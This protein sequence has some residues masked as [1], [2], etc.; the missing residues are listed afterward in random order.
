MNQTEVEINVWKPR[1][2]KRRLLCSV[3]Y[4]RIKEILH[5]HYCATFGANYRLVHGLRIR[6]T[7]SFATDM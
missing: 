1:V 4:N 3:I 2:S 6:A 7:D 5:G